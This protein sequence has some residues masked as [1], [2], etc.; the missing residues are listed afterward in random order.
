VAFRESEGYHTKE[1]LVMRKSWEDGGNP[2]API[3]LPEG[4]TTRFLRQ[5]FRLFRRKR[6]RGGEEISTQQKKWL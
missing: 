5:G 1:I 2:I 6:R 3:A 4:K